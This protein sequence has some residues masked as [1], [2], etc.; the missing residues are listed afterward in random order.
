[1]LQTRFWSVYPGAT[2]AELT[3]LANWGHLLPFLIP[4]RSVSF[5]SLANATPS[6]LS[7]GIFMAVTASSCCRLLLEMRT[8]ILGL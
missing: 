5:V 7:R 3:I 4:R 1:M 2:R 8:C 6:L